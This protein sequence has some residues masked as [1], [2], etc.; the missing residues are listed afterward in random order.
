MRSIFP[1]SPP[2]APPLS[3]VE[4]YYRTTDGHG[5]PF[6][7]LFENGA[8]G[9]EDPSLIEEIRLIRLFVTAYTSGHMN[10]LYELPKTDARPVSIVVVR[11]VLGSDILLL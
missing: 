6:V 8:H 3:F 9:V 5:N 2:L 10:R 1:K 7:I 11:Y 4:G